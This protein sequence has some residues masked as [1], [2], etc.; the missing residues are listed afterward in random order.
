[1]GLKEM[2]KKT[3]KDEKQITIERYRWAKFAFILSSFLFFMNFYYVWANFYTNIFA[4]TLGIMY[5]ILLLSLI[6]YVYFFIKKLLID[7]V[8]K[9][10][11]IIILIILFLIFSFLVLPLIVEGWFNWVLNFIKLYS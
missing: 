6:F 5:I 9:Y 2:I 3:F 1:M 8:P 7:K 10:L 4:N 11:F